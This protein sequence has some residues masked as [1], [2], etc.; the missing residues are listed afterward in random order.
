MEAEFYENNFP[1]LCEAFVAA[2]GLA[3]CVILVDGINELNSHREFDWLPEYLPTTCKLIF[4]T[5]CSDISHRCLSQRHDTTVVSFPV[6]LTETG[7]TVAMVTFELI[8]LIKYFLYVYLNSG[9]TF[10]KYIR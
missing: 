5:T 6:S 4:T 2:I 7:A 1:F 8:C 9:V 10:K 3:P